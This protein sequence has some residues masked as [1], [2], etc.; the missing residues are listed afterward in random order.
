MLR[1]NGA[2][3]LNAWLRKTFGGNLSYDEMNSLAAQ[4]PIGSEGLCMLPFGN[5]AERM[6]WA[7]ASPAAAGA[8]SISI[9]INQNIFVARRRRASCSPS[10]M[11]SRA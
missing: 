9:A 6:R 10:A 2:G 3:I 1:T 4:V 7:T 8:D 11:A 5:G